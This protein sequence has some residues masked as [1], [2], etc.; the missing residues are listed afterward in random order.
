M[1]SSDALVLEL[2]QSKPRFLNRTVNG[3]TI[4]QECE[5]ADFDYNLMNG[6][7]TVKIEYHNVLKEM[8][9]LI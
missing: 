7:L 4:G 6:E 3:A 1:K 8:S 5:I 2:I 9:Y